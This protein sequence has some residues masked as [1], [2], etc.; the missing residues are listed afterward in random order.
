MPPKTYDTTT[1]D[2]LQSEQPR[3]DWSREVIARLPE[4]WEEQ[5]RTLKAFERSRQVRSAT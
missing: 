2:L 5:A 4:N 1:S 3:D